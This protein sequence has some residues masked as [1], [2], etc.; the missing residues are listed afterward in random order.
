MWFDETIYPYANVTPCRC[1]SV[2][3]ARWGIFLVVDI[4]RQP[5]PIYGLVMTFHACPGVYRLNMISTSNFVIL[6]QS[7]TLCHYVANDPSPGFTIINPELTLVLITIVFSCFFVVC[8]GLSI[9]NSISTSSP[10]SPPF[11]MIHKHIQCSSRT[12]PVLLV[13]YLAI[14]LI[15]LAM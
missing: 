4:S 14:H 1:L 13:F 11:R 10:I 5:N 2:A 7:C 3:L 6:K 15:R 9:L 12:W 8:I